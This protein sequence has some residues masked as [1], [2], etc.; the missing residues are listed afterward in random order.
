MY[1]FILRL[2]ALALLLTSV[3]RAQSDIEGMD[4][5][6]R[7]GLDKAEKKKRDHNPA[8]A[9]Q[10]AQRNRRYFLAHISEE[11]NGMS[12]L[13]PVNAIAMARELNRQLEAQGF[14]HVGPGEIPDIV[15]TVKYG[16]GVLPNPY[17]GD[18]EI[19][20]YQ[21]SNSPPLSIWPV[22]DVFVGLEEKRQRASYEK[23]AIEVRAWKYPPPKDPNQPEELA[24]ITTMYADDPDHRDLD[25]IYPQLLAKGAPYFDHHLN[26]EKEVHIYVEPPQGHVKVGTP[27][28]VPEKN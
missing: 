18:Y 3:A 25:S 13:R 21:M 9:Q 12:L 20:R 23:L 7:A 27:E 2:L 1:A 5:G 14:H 6:V 26:P 10:S 8:Y 19:G 24:W 16:R 15:I 28:V 22:H 11:K 4:I 17:A